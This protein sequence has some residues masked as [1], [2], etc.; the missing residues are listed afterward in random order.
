MKKMLIAYLCGG[1]QK[2][3]KQHTSNYTKVSFCLIRHIDVRYGE[4]SGWSYVLG[5]YY[6]TTL[7]L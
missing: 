2:A 5:E 4:V 3:E 6:T 1:K 7:L